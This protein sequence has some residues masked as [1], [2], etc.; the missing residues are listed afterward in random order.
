[1][2]YELVYLGWG[3]PKPELLKRGSDPELEAATRNPE[4]EQTNRAVVTMRSKMY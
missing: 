1:M 3:D 4:N 2:P